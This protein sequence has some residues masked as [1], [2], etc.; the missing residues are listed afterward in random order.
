MGENPPI[1]QTG[2][3]LWDRRIHFEITRT[4]ALAPRQRV[5]SEGR[6]HLR[7]CRPQFEIVVDRRRVDFCTR[8]SASANNFLPI[9]CPRVSNQFS[10]WT[11]HKENHPDCISLLQPSDFLPLHQ[12]GRRAVDPP[13]YLKLPQPTAGDRRA[14]AP[15]HRSPAPV[16]IWRSFRGNVTIRPGTE[17]T[18]VESPV[19]PEYAHPSAFLDPVKAHLSGSRWY[20][21]AVKISAP[22]NWRTTETLK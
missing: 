19:S 22:F 9:A 12:P 3:R 6:G 7:V 4:L 14:E 15:R 20:Q 1:Q 10:L 11:V 5:R 2:S 13:R 18:D 17:L 16:P 21:Q 8:A